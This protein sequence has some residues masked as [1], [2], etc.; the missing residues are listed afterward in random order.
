M[1]D[2]CNKSV[3]LLSKAKNFKAFILQYNPDADIQQWL[4]SFNETMLIPSIMTMLVPLS[5]LN[6]LSETA[7]QVLA[8]MEVPDNQKSEVRDKMIKYFNM[9][10]EIV[11]T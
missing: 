5:K 10:C 7:D 1:A 4:S 8:K 2:C 11:M 9:F 3:F 6:K